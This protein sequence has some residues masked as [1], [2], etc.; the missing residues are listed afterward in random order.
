MKS[1]SCTMACLFVVLT[2]LTFGTILYGQEDV[3]G[4]K[5]CKHCGMDRQQYAH[6]RMLI[7]YEDG[8][9]VPACSLRC[10]NL[11][12][13]MQIDKAPKAVQVA[14]Y[15]SRK[16]IDADKATWVIGGDKPGVM[17][18][19]A[20]WAFESRTDAEAFVAGH[21]GSVATYAEAVKAATDDVQSDTAMIREKRKMRKM[22]MM[23]TQQ[24][25]GAHQ[26]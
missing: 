2:L 23:K 20:K 1:R 14:D 26:H 6:S 7:T 8:T 12:L 24:E 17:S 10:A 3:A 15:N 18:R 5:S 25:S 9:Q 4:H 16:L 21:G 22:Q 13:S 19:R 11:D